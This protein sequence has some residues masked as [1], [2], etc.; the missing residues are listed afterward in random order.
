MSA[1][2]GLFRELFE[3]SNRPETVPEYKARIRSERLWALATIVGVVIGVSVF[4]T[5]CVGAYVLFTWAV[6]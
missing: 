6:Q 3:K 5:F 4:G 2:D 1:Y